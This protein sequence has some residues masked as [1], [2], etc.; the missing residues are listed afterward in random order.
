[1]AMIGAFL[2]GPDTT[3]PVGKAG[4]SL[5]DDCVHADRVGGF[6]DGDMFVCD[7]EGDPRVPF[8][9]DENTNCPLYKKIRS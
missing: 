2:G 4:I 5:C 9:M 3:M 7:C 1:M 8:D 6:P